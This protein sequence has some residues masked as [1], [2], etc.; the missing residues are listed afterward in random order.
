MTLCIFVAIIWATGTTINQRAWYDMTGITLDILWICIIHQN[1]KSCFEDKTTVTGYMA[2]ALSLRQNCHLDEIRAPGCTGSCQMT[3]SV[4]HFRVLCVLLRFGTGD[5]FPYHSGLPHWYWG[6]HKNVQCQC[7]NPD[8]YGIGQ[9]QELIKTTKNATKSRT[10]PWDLL[11]F[12]CAAFL[13]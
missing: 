9:L 1:V 6:N 11:H 7:S 13:L 4:S 3:N 2:F 12:I 8:K 10:F 5:F